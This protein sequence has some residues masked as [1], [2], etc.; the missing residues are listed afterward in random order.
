MDDRTG[1]LL[2]TLGRRARGEAAPRVDVAHGVLS[3]LNGQGGASV[4]PLGWVAAA[5]CAAAVLVMYSSYSILTDLMDPLGSF[6]QAP[7]LFL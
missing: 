3:A 7:G 1:E 4:A 2:R 5:A 6:F